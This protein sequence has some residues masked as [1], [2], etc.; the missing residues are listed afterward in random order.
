MPQKTLPRKECLRRN[1][2]FHVLKANFLRSLSAMSQ[3][4]RDSGPGCF[5]SF[6]VGVEKE[7]LVNIGGKSGTRY[8]L[9]VLTLNKLDSFRRRL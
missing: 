7:S 1:S 6:Q 9:M 2:C 4:R 3:P 5:S 8:A